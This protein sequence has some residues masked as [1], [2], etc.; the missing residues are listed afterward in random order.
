M[1]VHTDPVPMRKF[2]SK[3]IFLCVII[4]RGITNEML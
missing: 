3:G 1:G 2:F 4:L